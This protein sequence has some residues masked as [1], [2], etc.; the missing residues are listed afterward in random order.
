MSVFDME[1]R[2]KKILKRKTK[3]LS[4]VQNIEYEQKQLEMEISIANDKIN[5][6][7]LKKL[8]VERY[9]YELNDDEINIIHEGIDKK[10]YYSACGWEDIEKLVRNIL[11]IKY[12]YVSMKIFLHK[13]NIHKIYEPFP[14]NIYEILFSNKEG[15]IFTTNC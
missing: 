3:L 6:S 14:T 2:L 10:N 5:L 9:N 12:K 4:D 1:N 8:I 7:L 15:T 13:L 11:E